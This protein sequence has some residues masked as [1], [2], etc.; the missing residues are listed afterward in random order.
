MAS[1]KRPR[2]P[3]QIRKQMWLLFSDHDL[4]EYALEVRLRVDREIEHLRQIGSYAA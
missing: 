3:N 4:R 1:P 2:D